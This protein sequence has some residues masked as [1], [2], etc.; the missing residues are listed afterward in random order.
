MAEP[1]HIA[2]LE[3]RWTGGDFERARECISTGME[4]A[5]Q[6]LGGFDDHGIGP[7]DGECATQ[8]ISFER[9]VLHDPE[10][11]PDK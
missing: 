8:V 9:F 5:V 11:D 6:L 7:F 4:I 3:I 1:V 2:L 10:W